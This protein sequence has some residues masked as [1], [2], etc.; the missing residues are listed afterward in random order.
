MAKAEISVTVA[1]L[2]M[3]LI[4]HQ[5]GRGMAQLCQFT[6][7]RNTEQA[8]TGSSYNIGPFACFLAVGF[9]LTLWLIL[10]GSFHGDEQFYASRT[11][12]TLNSEKLFRRI[13]GAVPKIAL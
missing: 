2:A 12:R 9:P 11:C 10:L 7:S 4:L 3:I 5:I 1:L 8:F 6:A 13:G